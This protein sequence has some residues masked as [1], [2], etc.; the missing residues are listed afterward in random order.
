MAKSYTSAEVL[1]RLRKQL[2]LGRPLIMASAGAGIIA[3]YIE[4]AGVDLIV[5][6]PSAVM[7]MDGHSSLAGMLPMQS[8]NEI[9]LEWGPRHVMPAVQD[10]P[11]LASIRGIDKS[12]DV[13]LSLLERKKLG[14]SGV[15]SFPVPSFLGGDFEKACEA[16]GLG[17]QSEVD[18]VRLAKQIGLFV[19]SYVFKAEHAKLMAIEGVDVLIPHMGVTMG[20]SMSELRSPYSLEEATRRTQ[21]FID[22]A[23]AINPNIIFGCHGGPISSPGD[24]Q[25]VLNHTDAVLFVAG[26]SIERIAI[27]E[28][29]PR[30]TKEFKNLSLKKLNKA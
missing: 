23:K 15:L 19:V 30:A 14:Y 7:R 3:K 22:E 11:V 25:Y 21:E 18:A 4:R 8:T 12:M 24:V 16:T 10:V 27:E 26:S 1:K 20:G 6:A 2:D 29:I 9:V 5:V 13:W 28:A 17:F